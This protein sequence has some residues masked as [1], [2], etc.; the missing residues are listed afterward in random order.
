MEWTPFLITTGALKTAIWSYLLM[1]GLRLGLIRRYPLAFV[2]FA[3]SL[4]TFWV[5]TSVVLTLGLESLEYYWVYYGTTLPLGLL[6]LLI[7]L[8][9]YFLPYRPMLRRDWIILAIIPVFIAMSLTE[10]ESAG[11]RILYVLFFYQTSVGF[12][13][14][15]RLFF[16]GRVRIGTNLGWLLY[17]I[18]VPAALQTFNRALN[19]LGQELWSYDAFSVVNELT[20]VISWCM[21][22]FGMRCYDPP[23]REGETAPMEKEEAGRRLDRYRQALW[24]WP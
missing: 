23:R 19:Y 18:T 3:G 6:A 10:P 8:R 14:A 16:S 22:A 7:L 24:R 1:Q 13:A 12:L 20:T 9:I 5:K 15:S 21:I 2:F 11:R 4:V 17:G